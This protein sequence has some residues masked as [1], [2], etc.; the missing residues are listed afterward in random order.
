M[1][2]LNAETDE[3]PEEIKEAIEE[4]FGLALEELRQLSPAE[5]LALVEER[6]IEVMRIGPSE[7]IH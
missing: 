4:T 1:K 5:L 2:I 3:L 7:T 6:G